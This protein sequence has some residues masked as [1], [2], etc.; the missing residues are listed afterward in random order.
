MAFI[1]LNAPLQEAPQGGAYESAL[2]LIVRAR[3]Q[4]RRRVAG[5]GC[6]GTVASGSSWEG[7][8]GGGVGRECIV[9]F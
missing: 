4:A 5:G 6:R 3:L 8:G 1:I 9:R 7:A 2:S